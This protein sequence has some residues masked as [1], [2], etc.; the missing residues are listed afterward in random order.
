MKLRN[1]TKNIFL[2]VISCTFSL[3][4]LEA[5]VRVYQYGFDSLLPHI[6]DSVHNLGTSGLIRASDHPEI[7]YELKPNV[8]TYFKKTKFATN[9]QGLRD[10]DYKMQKNSNTFRVAVIGD[11]F[12]LPAGIPIE[13]AYH[14]LL[15]KRLAREYQNR[16]IEFINFAVGGYNLRQYAAVLEHKVISYNPDLILIGFCA[17]NDWLEEKEY[18]ENRLS[19]KPYKVKPVSHPFFELHSVTL[20]KKL[21]GNMG[22]TIFQKM[23]DRSS[24][25]NERLNQDHRVYMDAMFGRIHKLAE[26]KGAH[27]VVVALDIRPLEPNLLAFL[28][29]LAEKHKFWF[30]DATQAF[31]NMAAS[32]FC[33]YQ[34]DCHP[35]EKANQIFA[36][37]IYSFLTN[38]RDQGKIEF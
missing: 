17:H 21:L 25:S 15:E 12:T 10:K 11:S 9:T 18:V 22:T 27:V 8:S 13:N 34:A 32:Q 26:S 19:Q 35:N 29:S 23:P 1:A 5:G 2:L 3:V 33:I 37:Q 38:L 7:I 14:S 30:L 31:R 4:M 20:I 6:M 28:E 36:D 16:E 24:D